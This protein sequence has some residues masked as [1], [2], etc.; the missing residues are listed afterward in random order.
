MT[1]RVDV[2]VDPDDD[3]RTTRAIYAL[4]ARDPH[5]LA[6][7]APPDTRTSSGIMWSILRALGKRSEHLTGPPQWH[8]V[9]RW[10]TAHEVREL[11]VL[12]AQ[13]LRHAT[14]AELIE[15]VGNG[16]RVH[17]TLI[18]NGA[19]E[20]RTATTTLSAFL[21]RPRNMAPR[22]PAPA[23]WPQVP[24]VH[25]LRFRYDAAHALDRED[26]RAV[27]QLLATA[28]RTLTGWL[29]VNRH[30]TS[31]RLAQAV[32]VIGAATDPEQAHIR[33]TGAQLALTIARLPAPNSQAL[34]VAANR[35]DAA[36]VAAIHEYTSPSVAGYI[37]AAWV[38]G[39]SDDLVEL[40]G[41]DQ[42]G[43]DHI[44]GT[45]VPAPARPVLR[46]LGRDY[47]PVL[48]PPRSST[49]PPAAPAASETVARRPDDPDSEFHAT[50][51]WLLRSHRHALR[52]DAI[53]EGLRATFEQ[54]RLQRLLEF[55]D[56]AYR[57]S[58]IALHGTFSRAHHRPSSTDIYAGRSTD[59]RRDAH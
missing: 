11:V 35:L 27:E 55:Y 15:Q 46:A 16:V 18:Y 42:I 43:D 7:S 10:L 25:P 30:P 44:L 56:D 58:P 54:L 36:R 47:D 14:R 33:R 53:A 50:L 38:T 21:E 31:D 2:I 57:A 19:D 26:F 17:I 3:I 37:L 59:I 28:F 49:R 41:G 23:A 45:Q 8:Q 4:A 9:R 1:P 12:R 34:P 20:G 48:T 51:E 40:I 32:A 29:A 39:L 24:R 13:H 22:A 6:A 52:A 5:V